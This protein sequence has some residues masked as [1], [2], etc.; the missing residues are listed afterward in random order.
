MVM[1]SKK[2]IL[3]S[4]DKKVQSYWQENLHSLHLINNYSNDLQ[5]V[6]K[7]NLLVFFHLPKASGLHFDKLKKIIGKGVKVLVLVDSLQVEQGVQLF[8]LGVKGYLETFT[9]PSLLERAV[10]EV[11]QGRVWLGQNILAALVKRV[12]EM[13]SDE[14]PTIEARLSNIGLT[15]REQAVAKGILAG[16]SNKEIANKL[17][18]T[19]R[20]VKAHVQSLLRKKKVKDRLAFVIKI[21]KTT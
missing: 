20:T 19:E 17:F 10:S 15:P 9:E 11:E 4:E 6:D 12:N 3:F 8:R 2:L 16:L 13:D 1:S 5:W 7:E 18:I 21:K 14:N